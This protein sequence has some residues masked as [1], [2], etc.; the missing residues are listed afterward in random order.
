M[1]AQSDYVE[2]TDDEKVAKERKCNF[3]T[4]MMKKKRDE[5]QAEPRPQHGDP[6]L[7]SRS[8]PLAKTK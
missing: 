8:L 3:L 1:F 4:S 6:Q 2:S 7:K 5:F